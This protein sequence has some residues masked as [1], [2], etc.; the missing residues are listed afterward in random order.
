MGCRR[1]EQRSTLLT[2]CRAAT[3]NFKRH[4]FERLA[5]MARAWTV[6]LAVLLTLL[7]TFGTAQP[8]EGAGNGAQVTDVTTCFDFGFATFCTK[9][10]IVFQITSAPSG[11]FKISG[12]ASTVSTLT[13][14]SVGCTQTS[15][16]RASFQAVSLNSAS[17]AHQSHYIQRNKLVFA[18]GSAKVT[19]TSELHVHFANGELQFLRNPDAVCTVS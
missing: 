13:Y 10:H 17:D 6:L 4:Q 5:M 14:A 15:T 12:A 18:C 11:T 16:A 19:C 9:Y 7:G 8:A 3:I 2:P 1:V